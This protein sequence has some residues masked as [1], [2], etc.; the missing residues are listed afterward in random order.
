MGRRGHA[1]CFAKLGM[2]SVRIRG[3]DARM[4]TRDAGFLYLERPHAPLHIG[5]VAVLEG[6][7]TLRRL[8]E[9]IEARLPRLRR[10]AQRAVP[11][12][13]EL[14]HPS[15]EDDPGFDVHNH[16]FRWALPPPGGRAELREA[17]RRRC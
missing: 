7:L 8:A 4:T 5:C 1:A 13:F 12:P 11:V 16:L 17:S 2:A 9:R 3:P 14:A 10:Y 6:P 15:W